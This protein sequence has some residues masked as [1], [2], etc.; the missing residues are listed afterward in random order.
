MMRRSHWSTLTDKERNRMDDVVEVAL[1]RYRKIRVWVVVVVLILSALILTLGV[2][3]KKVEHLTLY[4][5]HDPISIEDST[6]LN[7]E[8][9]VVRGDG[10]FADPYIIEGLSI[11]FTGS[12]GIRIANTT[13]HVVIK[14]CTIYGD[15]HFTPSEMAGGGVELYNASNVRM[16]FVTVQNA[17]SGVYASGTADE[18]VIGIE[19]EM[20]TISGCRYGLVLINATESTVNRSLIVNSGNMMFVEN[21]TSIDILGNS[22]EGYYSYFWYFESTRTPIKDSSHVRFLGNDWGRGIDISHCDNVS[23]SQSSFHSSYYEASVTASYCND[24]EISNISVSGLGIAYSANCLISDNFLEPLRDVNDYGGGMIG[25]WESSDIQIL[26]NDLRE[27][28][29]VSVRGTSRCA[30]VEN[31]I[32]EC[33]GLA[34][35]ASGINITILRNT[36]A[37]SSM[38]LLVSGN[39]ITVEAN[40]IYGNHAEIS[41]GRSEPNGYYDSLGNHSF[42][43]YID[44]FGFYATSSDSMTI[45]NNSI[46]SN[47]GAGPGYEGLVV[48]ECTNL[49]MSNNSI[50]DN[51]ILSRLDN[52]TISG[53]DMLGESYI[54]LDKL[55]GLGVRIVH[56]NIVNVTVN[57]QSTV[58]EAIWNDDYPGGGNYWSNYTGIDVKSGQNQNIA[59]S[60]GIGDTPLEITSSE[61]DLYPLMEPIETDDRTSPLTVFTMSGE[62]GDRGW[63]T[64]AVNLSLVSNDTFSGVN[65]ILIKIDDRDWQN[66]TSPVMLE[67][68]GTHT[69][70]YYS[71]DGSL[72]AEIVRSVSIRIDSRGPYMIDHG[73]IR[74]HFSDTKTTIVE[75]PFYDAGGSVTYYN[76]YG[77]FYSGNYYQTYTVSSTISSAEV[78]LSDGTV[79]YSATAYDEAGNQNSTEIEVVVSLNEN[80]Q[81]LSLTGPYGP[82]YLAAILVDLVLFGYIIRI[83]SFLSYAPLFRPPPGR[84]RE[85]GEVD[86]GEMEDGYPKY[87]KKM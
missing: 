25:V 15:Y 80:R 26:R 40:S 64:S 83:T 71:V 59:G 79:T 38:G 7:S 55:A 46:Y 70:K 29:G 87:F 12:A 54:T 44:H 60:D 35:I 9:G 53:N 5:V 37:L 14:N 81:P 28:R 50:N 42:P 18:P 36:I 48:S 69:V 56:N 19:F 66:Y 82:W 86:K 58:I 62:Q 47:S 13:E 1:A 39:D 41:A 74:Y 73:P 65:R 43:R 4:T 23:V 16:Q 51:S 3:V 68:E 57:D 33:A 27:A 78:E 75:F 31:V 22:I 11:R 49:S 67:S 45:S 30:I 32:S 8:N 2:T 84:D 76:F 17:Y 61:E 34:L 63:Y 10:S 85:A 20:G 77:G 72:N 6:A 21:C 24:L 52:T